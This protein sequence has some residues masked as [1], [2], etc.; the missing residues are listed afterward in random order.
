MNSIIFSVSY[1]PSILSRNRNLSYYFLPF[2][3]TLSCKRIAKTTACLPGV[4]MDILYAPWRDKYV[5]HS[6][7]DKNDISEP[8]VFCAI[9]LEQDS[10][11]HE[12][13]LKK[14][15]HAVVLL[16][17]YPYN[18]GHLLIIPLQHAA[19]LDELSKQARAEIIELV[20]A[21]AAILKDR[22]Q[23]EG[24]NAGLNLGRASGAGIP[25][26]LHFHVVPRWLGDTGFMTTIGQTRNVSVDLKKTYEELKPAFQALEI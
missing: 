25:E 2:F 21:S 12:F 16:N 5:K 11:H 26:H 8:C 19:N 24:V 1:A 18:G 22:L 17:I 6:G 4:S 13:I 15:E 7:K 10:A 9:F 20:S 14:T 3:D 23:T